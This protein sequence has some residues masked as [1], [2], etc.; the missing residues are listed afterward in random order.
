MTTISFL[1]VLGGCM[2]YLALAMS[3]FFA[4]EL[5]AMQKST[6]RIEYVPISEKDVQSGA[7]GIT[8]KLKDIEDDLFD[9]GIN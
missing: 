7:D 1:I 3:V 2:G 5:K 8:K 4:I 6:H 9:D